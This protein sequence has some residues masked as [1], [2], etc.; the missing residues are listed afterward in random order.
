MAGG[1]WV[2]DDP[3]RRLAMGI[4]SAVCGLASVGAWIVTRL[5]AEDPA[6]AVSRG[7]GGTVVRLLPPLAFLG[8]LTDSPWSPPLSGRLR[9]AGAG[10]LLVVF[11]LVMLATDILLHIMW[12]PTGGGRRSPAECPSA[13]PSAAPSPADGDGPPGRG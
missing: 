13:P 7:L 1:A 6:L 3:D 9:E 8:W 4:V 11:Y 5:G 2:G 10:G 12:G